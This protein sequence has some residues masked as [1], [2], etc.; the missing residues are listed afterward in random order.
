MTP[1]DEAFLTSAITSIGGVGVAF[2]TAFGG[3]V[4]AWKAKVKPALQRAPKPVQAQTGVTASEI[5]EIKRGVIRM[6][7]RQ[8]ETLALVRI[9]LDT[10]ARHE[11]EMISLRKENNGKPQK[12]RRKPGP[13][14]H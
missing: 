9:A 14:R 8:D 5:Q 7:A 12:G 11:K 6:E 2:L 10:L 1:I 3:L 13:L 4:T